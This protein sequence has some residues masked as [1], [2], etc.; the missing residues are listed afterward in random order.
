MATC[1]CIQLKNTTSNMTTCLCIQI[2][3]T[4]PNN[5]T[6]MCIQLKKNTIKNSIEIVT[7]INFNSNEMSHKK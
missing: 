4:V 7:L 5:A 1:T 6:C 3:N 2:E